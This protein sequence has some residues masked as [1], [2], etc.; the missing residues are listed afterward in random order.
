MKRVAQHEVLKLIIRR[1]VSV[2]AGAQPVASDPEQG[3]E[4]IRIVQRDG[5]GK[6]FMKRILE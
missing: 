5:S 2:E 3:E 6:E 1:D 4:S